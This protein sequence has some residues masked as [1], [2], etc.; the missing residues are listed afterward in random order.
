[1]LNFTSEVEALITQAAESL[2]TESPQWLVHRDLLVNKLVESLE[3]NASWVD[4]FGVTG[5]LNVPGE[6]EPGELFE[7]LQVAKDVGCFSTEELL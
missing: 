3:T 5:E 2:V 4:L 6:T 7:P 1:M